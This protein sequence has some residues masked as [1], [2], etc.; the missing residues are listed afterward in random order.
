M[1]QL[2]S[3]GFVELIQWERRLFEA[4]EWTKGASRC[5]W[6]RREAPALPYNAGGK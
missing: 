2:I 6:G 3:Y 4:S 5:R 1:C